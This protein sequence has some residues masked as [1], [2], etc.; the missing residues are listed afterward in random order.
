MATCKKK[1]EKK[2]A[3]NTAYGLVL[4]ERIGD[5]GYVYF[6]GADHFVRDLCI[7]HKFERCTKPVAKAVT[8]AVKAKEPVKTKAV[9]EEP[10]KKTKRKRRTSTED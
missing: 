6:D 1:D 7:R 9:N 5:D 8:K 10:K 2:N 4:I 3:Y